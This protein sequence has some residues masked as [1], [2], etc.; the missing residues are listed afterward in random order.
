MTEPTPAAIEAE[1]LIQIVCRSG[2]CPNQISDGPIYGH[3][4]CDYPDCRD[5][6]CDFWQIVNATREAFA[7]SLNTF[8]EQA[9][10][11]GWEAGRDAAIKAADEAREE[12]RQLGHSQMALGAALARDRIRAFTPPSQ[13]GEG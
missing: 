11:E 6:A 10:R 2:F 9:R 12:A 5:S 8:A 13:G 1:R 4:D 3:V 7:V